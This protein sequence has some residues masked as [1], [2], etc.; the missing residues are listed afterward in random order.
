MNPTYINAVRLLLAVA[1][2]VFRKPLFVLKGGTAINLFIRDMPRLSVDL[3]L[4][5]ADHRPSREA[6]LRAVSDSLGTIRE[7]VSRLGFQCELGTTAEG[8]DVKLFVQR[9]RTRIKLEVNHVFRGTVLPIEIRDLVET[10]RNAFLTNI[11]VPVLHHDELYGSKLVAV[12][13]RQHPRDLFD[14]LG[15]YAHGGLTPGIVECFVCYLAGH[16][17]PVHEV[18]FGNEIDIRPAFAND[19]EGMTREPVV[20]EVL[21]EVQRRLMAELPKALT[22][23]HRSFLSGLVRCEPDWSLM[24]C[25]H[26][27]MMP[28]IR[29]KLENL[30]RLKRTNPSKFSRQAEE[31][32]TRLS[33]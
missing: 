31:L 19:F 27:E 26:L 3:D 1:P 12:M 7:E 32:T 25:P 29:W 24:Q 5:C 4:V 8:S 13:D 16:N 10:A 33:R 14:V 20:L 22:D 11:Q 18:L 17:R 6:A 2:V 30:A 28:A 15:L 23:Q 9:D 21:I